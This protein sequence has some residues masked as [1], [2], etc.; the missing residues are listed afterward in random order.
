[1]FLC[2]RVYLKSEQKAGFFLNKSHKWGGGLYGLEEGEG[3]FG[4]I[5]TS[6]LSPRGT[7]EGRGAALGAGDSAA[8][9]LGGGSG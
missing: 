9:G 8:L 4:I 5:A 2:E 6:F 1:M 3:G 7:E